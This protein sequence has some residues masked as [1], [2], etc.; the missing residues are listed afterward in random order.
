MCVCVCACV[1]CVCVCVWCE[2]VHM[3]VCVCVC[4]SHI[5]DSRVPIAG[6]ATMVSGALSANQVRITLALTRR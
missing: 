5:T 6:Q 1:V 2:R 3:C 4:V